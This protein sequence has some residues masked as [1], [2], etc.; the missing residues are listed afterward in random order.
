MGDIRPCINCG[1]KH[2]IDEM[3]CCQ[4]DFDHYCSSC[5]NVLTMIENKEQE[6]VFVHKTT[7]SDLQKEQ[8]EQNWIEVF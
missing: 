7:L 5:D 2:H 3:K 8:P 1:G 4:Y 6:R